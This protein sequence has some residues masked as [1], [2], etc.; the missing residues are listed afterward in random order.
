MSRRSG[1]ALGAI[2]GIMCLGVSSSAQ[3]PPA[4][5]R[6]QEEADHQALRELRPIYEQAV[7][8]NRIDLLEPHLAAD[9]HG[10][11]VTGRT[12][13]SF[14]DLQ[15]YWRD[16]QNLIGTGGSYTTTLNRSSGCSRPIASSTADL[17]TW[18]FAPDIEP[19]RSSTIARLTGLRGRSD[20]ARG[21]ATRA[22]RNRSL[23]AFGRMSRRS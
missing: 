21:A 9:F 23:C 13:N 5:A 11:M 20:V 8:E 6:P 18:S 12:V 10:V 17:A 22:S 16:I 1:L 2:L 4:S 14:A 19:E 15:Q 3:Q 7:R